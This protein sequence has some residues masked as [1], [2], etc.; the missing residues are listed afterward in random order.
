MKLETKDV[1]QTFKANTLSP[2]TLKANTLSPIWSALAKMAKLPK[3]KVALKHKLRLRDGF[4]SITDSQVQVRMEVLFSINPFIWHIPVWECDGYDLI[5]L[6][7]KLK[8]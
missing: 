3:L 6:S 5:K 4:M 7:T 1:F 2:K 8:G